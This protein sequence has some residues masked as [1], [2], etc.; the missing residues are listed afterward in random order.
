[1]NQDQTQTQGGNGKVVAVVGVGPGLGTAIPRRFSREGFSVGLIARRQANLDAARTEIE[2]EIKSEIKSEIEAGI[3]AE[4]ANN[5]PIATAVGDASDSAS[6]SQAFA[7]V[8]EALGPPSVLVY[9]A[10]AF[11]RAGLL[12]L[13]EEQFVN[14][15]KIACLGAFHAARA[16]LPDMVARGRGTIL[17]T[18]ATGALRGS[19]NF[20]SMAVGKFGLRALGQSMAREFGP[21]GIHVAHVIVDGQINNAR[22]RERFGTTER[23]E[24]TFLD[25]DAIA[26]TYWHLHA[27]DRTSWTQEVDLRPFGE[28]F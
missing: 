26:E 11:A 10:G 8:S 20:A 16:V 27:Q 15:W 6:L 4:V 12:E 25:P 7:T 21:Q 23:P 2:S 19:A 24:D 14:S 9:N 17:L 13:T 1:M 22:T 3:E 5:S 18:G 28:K